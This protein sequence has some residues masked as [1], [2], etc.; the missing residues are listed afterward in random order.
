MC[1]VSKGC[2]GRKSKRGQWKEKEES[3]EGGKEEYKKGFRK[4]HLDEGK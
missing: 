4:G 1:L 2:E 3:T